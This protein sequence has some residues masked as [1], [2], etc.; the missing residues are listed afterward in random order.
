M[1]KLKELRIDAYNYPFHASHLV[2]KENGNLEVI[3]DNRI[4]QTKL[5]KKT[6]FL[7]EL[8]GALILDFKMISKYSQAKN[9][10]H[11][12]ILYEDDTEESHFYKENLFDNNQLTL[13]SVLMT[14]IPEKFLIDV[15]LAD[16]VY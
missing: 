7:Q 13:R 1:K 8:E 16:E 4:Y 2:I 14:Y 11:I 15:V 9:Y 6:K 12:S 5:S 3:K 10:Y